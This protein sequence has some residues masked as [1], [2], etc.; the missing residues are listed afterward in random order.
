MK[1]HIAYFSTQKHSSN[2]IEKL[3]EIAGF[4]YKRQFIYEISNA[5]DLNS[6]MNDKFGNYVV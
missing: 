4:D 5:P 2:V 1:N 3:I 6:I